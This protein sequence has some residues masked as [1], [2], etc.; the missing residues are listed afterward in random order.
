[1]YYNTNNESGDT[2]LSSI[3]ST[4][5]QE[6]VVL[7]I[8]TAFPRT[9]FSPDD[10]Q[11]WLVDNSEKTYPITSIRRAMTNLTNQ[12]KLNKTNTMKT[13]VWGKSTHTWKLAR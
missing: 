4:A 1:M 10:I 5:K 6:D 11:A 12:K 3:N 9:N 2:L 8:F 13:G 7:S